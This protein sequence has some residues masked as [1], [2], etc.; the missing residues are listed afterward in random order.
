MLFVMAQV[1]LSIM[2]VLLRYHCESIKG[3]LY[4]CY[5]YESC[6]GSKHFIYHHIIG[7]VT[8][9]PPGIAS[10][11]SGD[12]LELTCNTTGRFLEWSFSL[13]PENE[14]APTRYTWVLQ[15]SGPNNLQTFQRVIDSMTFL[16]SRSSTENRLPVT[17]ILLISSVRETLNALVVN[18]TD[19]TTSSIASTIINVLTDTQIQCKYSWHS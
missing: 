12:D 7:T 11:C 5:Y 19:V 4:Y 15:N 14:T 6:N 1:L 8:L 2:A 3:T 10:V 17:S 13:I 9:S 16:Y 18:C